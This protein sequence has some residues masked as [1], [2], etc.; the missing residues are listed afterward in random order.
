M[1]K[2]F[3]AVL[4]F[5]IFFTGL[6]VAQI[7]KSLFIAN[8]LGQNISTINLENGSVNTDAL[9]LG[10]FPNYLKIHGDRAYVI[11]S[12]TNEVQIVDLAS[13]STIASIDL[14]ANT[15]PWAVD[16]IN[17][18]LAAVSLWLADQIAI[19]NVNSR[20]IV[21]HVA[22]GISPEGVKYFEGKIYV[23]NSGFN[24][25]G[26][27]PGTVTVIDASSY[28]VLDTIPV[29]INPQ[30]LDVSSQ[31]RLVVICTGDYG[32]IKSQLD[33]IDLGSI[34]LDYSI[35]LNLI[36]TGVRVNSHN[37]CYMGTSF[38]GVMVYN[39]NSESFERDE[40]QTLPGGSAI[41]FDQQENAYL[42]N[43]NTDSVYVFSSSHQ[44]ITTFQVGDGP[45]SLDLYDP[46]VSSVMAE[47]PEKISDFILNQ[48][49]PNP[50]NPKTL[51]SYQISRTSD[52]E[53]ILIN[54]LGQRVK[55]LVQEKQSAGYYEAVW[56]GTDES[57][58]SVASGI[59]LF[60][61]KTEGQQSV[62]KMH[63]IR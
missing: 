41:V 27:D 17:D 7:P 10:L 60:M 4:L 44:K 51:I 58:V 38:D 36:A 32:A 39:L 33:I 45:V 21:H 29:S 43:F 37:Q 52:V 35:I 20:Q 47:Q 5:F 62:K 56:N 31:D 48:N 49:Y 9:P 28:L 6:L 26:Y 23:A 57:G 14:G 42:A 59:Y 24:G 11:N 54:L 40:T 12:G 63:L 8:S 2:N 50:F 55:T 18:S 15:N 22:V 25:A 34:T 46:S 1:F 16:F 13:I 61:L 19:I 30:D 3:T 53:L